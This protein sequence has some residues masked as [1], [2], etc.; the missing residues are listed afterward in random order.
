M[1][2]GGRGAHAGAPHG[3]RRRDLVPGDR[4]AAPNSGAVDDRS[5]AV[6][7]RQRFVIT[8]TGEMDQRLCAEFEDLEVTLARGVT[9]LQVLS[10]DPSVL[11]GVLHRI[12]VLGLEVLD[13]RPVGEGLPW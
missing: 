6:V 13:V 4:P 8:L 10:P 11:H 9:R 3:R 1:L 5:G 2:R 12:E 7:S